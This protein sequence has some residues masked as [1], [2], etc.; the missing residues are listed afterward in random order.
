MIDRTW[1][2]AVFSSH[3]YSLSTEYCVSFVT[4]SHAT[5]YLEH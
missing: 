1:R 2:K 4:V 3:I 5:N